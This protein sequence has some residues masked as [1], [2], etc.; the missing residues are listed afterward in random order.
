M[1]EILEVHDRGAYLYVR[2]LVPWTTENA[3]RVIDEARSEAEAGGFHR[4]LFDLTFWSRPYTEMTR[5]LTG[6]YLAQRLGGPY[7]TAAFSNPEWINR[8]GENVAVNRGADF[9]V[10]PDEQSAVDW[11]L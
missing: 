5:F 8:F 11:L 3:K 9:R 2:V 10:F 7:K 6:E 1:D 4:I